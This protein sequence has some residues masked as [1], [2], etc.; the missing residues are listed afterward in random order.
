MVIWISEM[1][2]HK[3]QEDLN[4]QSQSIIEIFFSNSVYKQSNMIKCYI[5][6]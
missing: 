1:D 3:T 6:F 2:K 4:P 5:M